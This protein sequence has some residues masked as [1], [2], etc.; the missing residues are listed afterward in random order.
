MG[1]GVEPAVLRS[2]VQAASVFVQ[3][4][5]QSVVSARVK[6]VRTNYNAGSANQGCIGE[7]LGLAYELLG[8]RS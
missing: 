2:A 4:F 3:F 5:G 6:F 8:Q 7:M 1:A